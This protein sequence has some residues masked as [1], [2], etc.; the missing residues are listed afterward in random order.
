MQIFQLEPII[1]A[2]SFCVMDRQ[3]GGGGTLPAAGEENTGFGSRCD[4]SALFHRS[5]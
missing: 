3:Q 1:P 4:S 2:S 5:S